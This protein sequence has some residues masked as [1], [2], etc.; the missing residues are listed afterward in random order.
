[1]NHPSEGQAVRS[2]AVSVVPVDGSNLDRAAAVHSA[3]WQASHRAFCSPDFIALHSPAH[4]RAYLAE[5]IAGGSRVFLLAAERP[6]GIVSVTGSLI[7]DLY[8][9][10]EEQN[11]GLGSFL[12]RF[13]MRQCA[14]MPTLWILENNAGAERLYRRMGFAPTGRRN[15]ITDG[16]DEIEFALAPDP[17]GEREC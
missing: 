3:A 6:V 10:P 1:M 12:L 9:L 15:R 13:A 16:L 17:D 5:K 2:A 14:G 4:Q 11:K 7:E 8:I